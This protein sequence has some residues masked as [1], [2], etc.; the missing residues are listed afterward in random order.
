MLAVDVGTL[1]ACGDC[2]GSGA[3][4]TGVGGA[5]GSLDLAFGNFREPCTS[6][7]FVEK[8]VTVSPGTAWEALSDA[9]LKLGAWCWNVTR[10]TDAAAS[11]PGGIALDVR[12]SARLL[13]MEKARSPGDAA[14]DPR[15]PCTRCLEPFVETETLPEFTVHP[16]DMRKNPPLPASEPPLAR[17]GYSLTGVGMSRGAS[18]FGGMVPG[19]HATDDL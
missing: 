5:P 15:D 8:T 4:P 3:P 6:H 2:P 18:L 10:S 7:I 16:Y 12:E 9:D 13:G 19:G 17:S 11:S 14:M 1:S